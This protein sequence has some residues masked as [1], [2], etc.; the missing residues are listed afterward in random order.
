LF[1]REIRNQPAWKG[2]FRKEERKLLFFV[3][4]APQL[5]KP[6]KEEDG[7]DLGGESTDLLVNDPL[8]KGGENL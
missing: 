3:P 7:G 5:G 4:G 1:F 2:L 8:K 6:G